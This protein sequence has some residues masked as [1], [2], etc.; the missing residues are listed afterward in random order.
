MQRFR[1]L[2]TFLLIA[3]F[4]SVA[5]ADIFEWTDENGVRHF[6][7]Y[8][9][10]IQARIL[11]KA[12]E[13][14]YDDSE[15]KDRVEAESLE[16]LELA[17]LALAEKEA[18]LAAQQR[19]AD[20]RIAAADQRA[21]EALQLAEDLAEQAEKINYNYRRRS[22]S[23]IYYPYYNHPRKHRKYYRHGGNI[24]FKKKHFSGYS[25]TRR[26][27]RHGGHNTSRN[28]LNKHHSVNSLHNVKSFQKAKAHGRINKLRGGKRHPSLKGRHN[29]FHGGRNNH[30]R[31]SGGNHF[32]IGRF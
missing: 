20:Q 23:Y 19:E 26:F 24:Y 5:S 10:P 31:H 7:N 25:Q 16:K 17:K 4:G 27:S 22:E 21:A 6:T 28:H 12:E 2:P 32:V 18:V 15:N 29:G 1:I 3:L 14:P 13:L 11:I 9:P 30:R 8:A